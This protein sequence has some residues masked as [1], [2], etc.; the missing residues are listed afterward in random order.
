MLKL[1]KVLTRISISESVGLT[2][3]VLL[4]ETARLGK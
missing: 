2:A 4:A 3:A 1:S